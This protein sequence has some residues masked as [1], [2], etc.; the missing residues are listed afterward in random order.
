MKEEEKTISDKIEEILESHLQ[1]EY[2]SYIPESD[3]SSIVAEIM[4]VITDNFC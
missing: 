4:K 3:I 2:R 1:H